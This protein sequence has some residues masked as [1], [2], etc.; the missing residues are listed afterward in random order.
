MK[1]AM[2]TTTPIINSYVAWKSSAQKKVQKL[3]SRKTSDDE[4][5]EAPSFAAG[6]SVPASS[7]A[8]EV[9]DAAGNVIRLDDE[10]KD[11]PKPVLTTAFDSAI[12]PIVEGG[13]QATADELQETIGDAAKALSDVDFGTD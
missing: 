10:E 12:W 11:D 9:Y 13:K 3:F 4:P 8:S 1:K 5:G 2:L 7:G 6:S